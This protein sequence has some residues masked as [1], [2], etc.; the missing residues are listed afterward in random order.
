MPI[1]R[2]FLD[3]TTRAIVV[4]KV[5]PKWITFCATGTPILHVE[6]SFISAKRGLR[7]GIS[8]WTSLKY[9]IHFSFILKLII[10]RHKQLNRPVAFSAVHQN[11]VCKFKGRFMLWIRRDI[12]RHECVT[13]AACCPH[14]APWQHVRNACVANAACCRASRT[15]AASET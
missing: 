2:F 13:N 15:V 12:M 1:R 5:I 7:R 3:G 4:T 6:A 14:C 9:C 10:C 11:C 8:S